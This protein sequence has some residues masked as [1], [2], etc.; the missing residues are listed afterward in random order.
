MEI[1]V[2]VIPQLPQVI[3]TWISLFILYLILRKFLYEPLDSF[4]ST[5]KTEINK[6]IQDAKDLRENA[7]S[8]RLE[9]EAK[10]DEVREETQDILNQAR[11]RS[12]ILEKEMLEEAKKEADAIKSRA[13]LDI[14]REKSRALSSVH[15]E[16]SEIALLVASQ[17]IN[18]EMDDRVQRELV[19]SFIDEVG[20]GSWKN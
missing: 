5:R 3:V 4:L 16:I 13:M 20:S 6:D 7:E 19:D 12:E 15:D 11:K 1:L 17:V 18:S 2:E 9:Y 8:L 10:L 14:E